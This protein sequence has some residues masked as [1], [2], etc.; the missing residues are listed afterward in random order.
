MIEKYPIGWTKKTQSIP[1]LISAHEDQ[2]RQVQSGW[3]KMG[4]TAA[5]G[6]WAWYY[7]TSQTEVEGAFNEPWSKLLTKWSSTQGKRASR[8]SRKSQRTSGWLLSLYALRMRPDIL[9]PAHPSV[10][11]GRMD[12]WW[13]ADGAQKNY[14]VWWI[15]HNGFIFVPLPHSLFPSLLWFQWH[16]I[17]T[18]FTSMGI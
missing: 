6:T 8:W 12:N 2:E 4:S 13:R 15:L 1:F 14:H 10:T 7:P 3:S 17:W 18:S 11:D 16:M 9:C 5:P